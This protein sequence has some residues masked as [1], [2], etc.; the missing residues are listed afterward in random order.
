[1]S[2]RL[3]LSERALH[4]YRQILRTG[5]K[6]PSEQ[7]TVPGW[8]MRAR[9]TLHT[10]YRIHMVAVHCVGTVMSGSSHV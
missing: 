7:V 8:P 5:R 10:Q 4:L 6:W 1:M 2:A 3:A 9:I